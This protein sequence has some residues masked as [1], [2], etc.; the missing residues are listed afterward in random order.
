M[1]E[2][3]N[4]GASILNGFEVIEGE[5]PKP[6]PPLPRPGSQEAKTPGLNR[7]NTQDLKLCFPKFQQGKRQWHE[8][9]SNLI[10]V[11]VFLIGA[12]TSLR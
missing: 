11:F 2:M 1:L 7:V 8:Q 6:P 10:L 4:F 3:C 5:P 12:L 9:F